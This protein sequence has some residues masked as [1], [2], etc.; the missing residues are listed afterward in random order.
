MWICVMIYDFDLDTFDIW[1]W[2]YGYGCSPSLL[3][4]HDILM[5][6]VIETLDHS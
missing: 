2:T 5:I 4:N 3:P 1:L 6:P